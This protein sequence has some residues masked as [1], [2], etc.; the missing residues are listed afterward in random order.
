[1]SP[2]TSGYQQPSYPQPPRYPQPPVSPYL[3]PQ[4]PKKHVSKIVI[5]VSVIAAIALLIVFAPYLILFSFPL[6]AG[7]DD[8]QRRAD[9]PAL[10]RSQEAKALYSDCV[11]TWVEP[12]ALTDKAVDGHGK[13]VITSYSIDTSRKS[14]ST[15]PVS[16]G[17]RFTVNN[18]PDTFLSIS[19]SG[20]EAG[21]GD[22]KLSCEA[23]AEDSP[24]LMKALQKHY[25]GCFDGDD[26]TPHDG[27]PLCV[28]GNGEG[29]LIE[30]MRVCD[31]EPDG[32]I[33]A[34]PP[35]KSDDD[36]DDNDNGAGGLPGM[37]EI[38]DGN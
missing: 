11:R 24:M 31:G 5:I 36:D 22:E 33:H 23:D 32:S 29:Q 9:I 17:F 7:L 8:M 16:V 3:P 2:Y 15:T 30:Y 1:M 13:P 37:P 34:C 12:G 21:G 26:P 18:N 28:E 4:K 35:P 38:P 20:G 19:L 25:G 14:V 27:E 6:M 10:A